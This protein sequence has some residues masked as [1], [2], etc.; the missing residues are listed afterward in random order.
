[1][2]GDCYTQLIKACCIDYLY[3]NYYPDEDGNYILTDEL[4]S[5]IRAKLKEE[6]MQEDCQDEHN[7]IP[8]IVENSMDTYDNKKDIIKMIMALKLYSENILFGDTHVVENIDIDDCANEL[9][10]QVTK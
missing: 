8:V 3:E 1:M 6:W 5:E 9:H 2:D 10:E 4:N 7:F